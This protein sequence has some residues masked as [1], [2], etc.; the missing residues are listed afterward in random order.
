MHV[1]AAI[2]VHVYVHSFMRV[3]SFVDHAH[4]HSTS[5]LVHTCMVLILVSRCVLTFKVSLVHA[6]IAIKLC[7]DNSCMS[8][9]SPKWTAANQHSLTN[10]DMYVLCWLMYLIFIPIQSVRAK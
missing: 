4:E 7:V 8:I 5:W 6:L 10:V 1:G 3:C 9:V 2:L